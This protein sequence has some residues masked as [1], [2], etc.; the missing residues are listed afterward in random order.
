M[1]YLFQGGPTARL[2][3]A[4]EQEGNISISGSGDHSIGVEA[5]FGTGLFL[6][7]LGFDGTTQTG[8][9]DI[10]DA[11]TNGTAFHVHNKLS[12]SVMDTL[13]GD[14]LSF[15]Q[16][17]GRLDVTNTGVAGLISDNTASV[18]TDSI[19]YFDAGTGELQRDSFVDYAAK[20]AA[21]NGIQAG[22]GALA[23]DISEFSAQ[24]PAASDAFL[25]LD[26]DGSTEQLTTTNALAELF[27]GAGLGASSAVMEVEVSGALKVGAGATGKVGIS[28]S[29]AGAG[30]SHAGG[31]DSIS[32]LAVDSTELAALFD[33]ADIDVANDSIIFIDANDSNDIKQESVPDLATRMVAG[34][35]GLAASSGVLSVDISE[36]SVVAPANNDS[37]LTL[38]SDGATEQLTTTQG[39]ANLF[40]GAGLGQ[41][42]AVMEVE[43]SGALKVGAG[44][45]GKVGITGSIAGTGLTFAGGDDSISELSVDLNELSTGAI[46]NGDFITFIDVNDSNNSKKEHIADVAELFAGA[47]MTATN[48]VI[49]IIPGT[50][51]GLSV[52]ANNIIVD[53]D[54]LGVGNIN[55]ADDTIAFIDNDDDTTK[56]ETV[57]DFVDAIAGAG[58]TATAGVLSVQ[59]NAVT[60][61]TGSQDLNEGFNVATNDFSSDVTLT[62]PASPTV[63]DV[64]RIKA[65]N[66]T[67]DANIVIQVGN[68]S[69]KIDV[70]DSAI[71]IES[72]FGAVSCVYAVNNDWRIF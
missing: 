17:A 12:G 29:I 40:A 15:T 62:L 71:R 55:V 16:A 24:T 6:A 44:A 2:S 49:N 3:G 28:G 22:G 8:K 19:V 61:V 39:L 59:S 31:V 57:S 47:G 32:S 51:P 18:S 52:G 11:A 72:P 45:S 69:H 63:G 7:S 5:A 58:L 41:T 60:L 64:V 68:G 21:G 50:N 14:A 34:T 10:A 66:L 53:L 38:D 4:V 9:L 70:T 56:K 67:N 48:S 25:T 30:L 65:K 46:E 20:L 35:N 33:A 36:F 26:S 27:A 42:D 54:T 23:I 13:A 1:A 37:F 43:V